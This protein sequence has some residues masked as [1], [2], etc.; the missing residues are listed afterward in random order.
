MLEII[1]SLPAALS[2][3]ETPSHPFSINLDMTR[4]YLDSLA[5]SSSAAPRKDP[6][7]TG[8]PC[9]K[10]GRLVVL[11]SD[12]AQDI[13]THCHLTGQ[14]PR[15]QCECGAFLCFPDETPKEVWNS[16]HAPE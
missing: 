7:D 6:D 4:G 1:M 8:I 15:V 3:K 16:R 2:L 11:H 5:H 12:E 9:R 14:T 13:Y 10:C